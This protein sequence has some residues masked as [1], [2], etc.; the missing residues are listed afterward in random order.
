MEPYPLHYNRRPK[1]TDSTDPSIRSMI[2][3]LQQMVQRLG[4]KVE[5]HCDG[6]ET[7]VDVAEQRSEE[8]FIVLEMA[9]A[10][11]DVECADLDKPIVP[12]YHI[13]MVQR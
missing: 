3:E 7:R 5:G 2:D 8:R 9:C 4:E 10:E 13:E 1:S 12:Q 6:L 11:A